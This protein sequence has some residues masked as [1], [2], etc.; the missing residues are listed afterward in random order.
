[1]RMAQGLLVSLAMLLA[2]PALADKLTVTGAWARPTPPGATMGVVYFKLHNGSQKSDRLLKLTTPV[3]ASAS[4]HRTEIVEDM[5]RM[6]EVSVLHV[7][8]GE[9]LEFAPGGLHVMLMGLKRPL[10]EG[11]VFELELVFEVAGRVKVRV[12]ARRN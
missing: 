10:K 7:A 12:T 11:Q 1:M 4:V 5:A 2:A 8:P 3:A 6:R 9:K